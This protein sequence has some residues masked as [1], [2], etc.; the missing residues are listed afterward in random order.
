MAPQFIKSKVVANKILNNKFRLFR[1]KILSQ[2]FNFQP[3][4]FVILKVAERVYRDYSITSLPQ[5]LPFWEVLLDVTPQGPGCRYLQ[6]LRPG[7]II[8]T[9]QPHGVFTIKDD[10]ATHLVMGATGCGFASIKPI[11]ETTLGK[12]GVEKIDFLWGLRYQKDITFQEL[13]G[14]WQNKHPHFRAEVIL[15]QPE[16]QWPHKTGH[17][18][19]HLGNLAQKLPTPKT[20]VYLCGSNQMITDVRKYF[21]QKGLSSV[22]IYFEKCY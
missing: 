10:G 1:F 20:S 8:E 17:I 13:L 19:K 16:G 4:Q 3:G 7:D 22:K 18:T 11:I 6:N 12:K 5:T 14:N 9:S 15:S 2:A 21:Q